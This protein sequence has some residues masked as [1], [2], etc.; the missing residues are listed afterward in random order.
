M[1][2]LG[3]PALG[4]LRCL[5]A[6]R[7]VFVWLLLVLLIA[8][9]A[10][11]TSGSRYALVPGHSPVQSAG[12]QTAG[13]VPLR[14][15]AD[16]GPAAPS[17]SAAQSVRVV[18][19]AGPS[20][21]PAGLENEGERIKAPR[22]EPVPVRTGAVDPPSLIQRLPGGSLHSHDVPPEPELPAL[23]VVELSISRT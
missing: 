23:T 3:S 17:A 22:G 2:T 4:L 10:S 13:H 7:G 5:V 12:G 14:A 9:A 19:E 15:I 1:A 18:H 16:A 20:A 6:L 21:E 11:Y 8:G